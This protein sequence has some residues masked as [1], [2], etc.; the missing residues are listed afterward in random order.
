MAEKIFE[1]IAYL[2]A[3][4][5]LL[6]FSLSLLNKMEIFSDTVEKQLI[7]FILTCFVS[8][9]LVIKIYTP[10]IPNWYMKLINKNYHL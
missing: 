2:F 10:I 4:L 8:L 9:F 1:K 5:T 3:Y 7:K 6:S